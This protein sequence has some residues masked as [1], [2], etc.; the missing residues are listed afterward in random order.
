MCEQTPKRRWLRFSLRTLFVAVTVLALFGGYTA[1]QLHQSDRILKRLQGYPPMRGGVLT[2]KLQ[3]RPFPWTTPAAWIRP[4][5]A[6][7]LDHRFVSEVEAEEI[8]RMFP[9]ANVY[10][11]WIL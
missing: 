4:V 8:K 9:E 10:F 2:M 11:P 6:I 7:Q 3:P 1:N 5:R